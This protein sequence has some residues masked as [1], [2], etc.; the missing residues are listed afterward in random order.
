MMSTTVSS[1]EPCTVS[2]HTSQLVV[3]SR[4]LPSPDDF[5]R[6]LFLGWTD[7][8]ERPFLFR[9]DRV[10]DPSGKFMVVS[11]LVTATCAPDWSALETRE[12]GVFL[13]RRERRVTWNL[14]AGDTFAFK[15]RGHTATDRILPELVEA[16]DREGRRVARGA[17]TYTAVARTYADRVA[18]LR[19]RFVGS[20]CA[21]RRT[22]LGEEIEPTVSN[23]V[24]LVAEKD[25]PDR[26]RERAVAH[27]ADFD[28]Q[29]VVTDPARFARVLQRGLSGCDRRHLGCGLVS[30][31]RIA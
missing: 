1:T 22:P 30:I 24:D 11:M 4:R 7:K 20:G 21:L 8:K 17:P 18:W 10:L 2:L 26:R 16:A 5:H 31:R 14:H 12:P 23:T 3:R 9:A 29:L 28:G 13:E 15:V 19:A 27:V 6:L 25:Q